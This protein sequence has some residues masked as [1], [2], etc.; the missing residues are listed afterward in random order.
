MGKLSKK[1]MGGGIMD[2]IRCDELSYLI[3][4]WH[5]E[6]TKA[7]QSRKENAIRLG[8]SLRVKAGS[9]AAFVYDSAKGIDYIEGPYDDIIKTAN[10][11]VIS[12]IIGLAY[13]GNSPFQA[14]IYFINLA[15]IVQVKFAVFAPSLVAVQTQR[16]A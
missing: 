1:P 7:G 8:S 13:D 10:L 11:P 16:P 2:V 5:P 4:K 9:V 14:E 15:Q 3:W 6:G 12:N